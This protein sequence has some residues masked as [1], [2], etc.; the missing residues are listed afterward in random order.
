M[1]PEQCWHLAR[2]WYADKPSP[3]WRRKTL[4]E[5]EAVLAEV[6]LT[7]PFWSLR[8]SEPVWKANVHGASRLSMRWSIAT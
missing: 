8:A 2:E 5:T 4:E 7:E 3:D 1:T 6:G